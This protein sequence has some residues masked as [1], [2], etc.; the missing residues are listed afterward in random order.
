MMVL[1]AKSFPLFSQNFQEAET[2]V[3]S[4]PESEDRL[5]ADYG[6]NA[7]ELLRMVKSLQESRVALLEG[8]SH[9]LIVAHLASWQYMETNA[10]NEVSIRASRLRN[11][12]KTKL[13]LPY[14]CMAFILIAVV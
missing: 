11:Y 5:F 4:F 6:E 3:F 10:V 12:M 1:S 9:L 7:V 8:T 13:K 2:F 14:E